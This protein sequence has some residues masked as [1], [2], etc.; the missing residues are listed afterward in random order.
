MLIILILSTLGF[1]ASG[2]FYVA[3]SEDCIKEDNCTETFKSY[4][5][6]MFVLCLIIAFY[7]FTLISID[8]E[9]VL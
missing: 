6:G 9:T 1:I 7:S 5:I 4:C 2:L 8:Y 3:L